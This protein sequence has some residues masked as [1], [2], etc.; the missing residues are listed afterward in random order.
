MPTVVAFD[1]ALL[2]CTIHVLMKHALL[3]LFFFARKM[4][5]MAGLR[6][7]TWRK[8]EHVVLWVTTTKSFFLSLSIFS[9]IL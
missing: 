3:R 4:Q 5:I 2:P 7:W 8:N 9:V 6:R 1:P